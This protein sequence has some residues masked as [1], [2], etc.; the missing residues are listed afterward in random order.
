MNDTSEDVARQYDAMLLALP[1]GRRVSMAL[2]MFDTAKTLAEAGLR[3]QGV[4]DPREIRRRLLIA[5][6]GDEFSEAIS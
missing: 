6:Y 4:T 2:A 3:A 1:P 5:F